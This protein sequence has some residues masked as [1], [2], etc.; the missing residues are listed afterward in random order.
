MS[1]PIILPTLALADH[2]PKIK[3]RL[4]IFRN[5]FL[6]IQIKYVKLL[7]SNYPFLLNQFP[8]IATIVGQ[9]VDWASPFIIQKVIY[10][11]LLYMPAHSLTT[12]KKNKLIDDTIVPI[13]STI[14][15]LN[16]S[17][18]I[19]LINRP[20]KL[21]HKVIYIIQYCNP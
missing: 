11:Y 4:E 21:I 6:L 19:P 17:P 15:K 8:I 2:T 7:K 14:L 9:P 16:R 1:A 5:F 20:L 12:P 10:Q 3:P 13:K 18:S